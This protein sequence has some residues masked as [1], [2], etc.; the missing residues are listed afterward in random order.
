MLAISLALAPILVVAQ[1]SF[2]TEF[3]AGSTE[4]TADAL[5]ARLVGKTF[6]FKPVVGNHVRIEY[7]D[8]Y[9]F[10]N[11]GATSDSGKWRVEG[12]SVCNEW[13]KLPHTCSA[14]RLANDVLYVKRANN[15]EV[16]ALTP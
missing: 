8:V 13:T 4:L 16:V 1:A 14:F 2:P 3:P 15:G 10:V 6:S 7:K 9:A 5:R 12:S 11:V